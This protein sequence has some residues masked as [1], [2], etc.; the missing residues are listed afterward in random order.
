[1]IAHG[2]LIDGTVVPGT[3]W[4]LRDSAAWWE[5]GERGTI[6]RA[7]LIDLLIFHWS[8]GEAGL[9]DPDGPD[10][11]LTEYDDDGVRLVAAM[12]DRK[13][14]DGSPMSVAIAFGIG[15][16]D[17]DDRFANVWQ[18]CDIGRV[19]CT[20]VARAWNP[21]SVGVEII[22]A[23]MPDKPGARKRFDLRRRP[24]ITVPLIGQERQ[25]LRFFDGQIRSA[26]RLAEMLAALDGHGGIRI[27]RRVPASLATRRLSEREAARW[28]GA[29]EH[30]LSPWTNKLDAGGQVMTALEDAG[31]A[32][33]AA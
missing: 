27:P 21:R 6:R 20:H 26:I 12:K 30:C 25:V 22:S 7:S 28:K 15:A 13:H 5:V 29:G 1:M 14:D 32:R 16:C 17:P 10:L 9:R 19:A 23:G 31:W 33:A 11:P 24:R 18:C 8:A 2:L 3:D 4:I